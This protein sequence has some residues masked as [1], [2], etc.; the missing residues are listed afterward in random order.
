MRIFGTDRR[1]SS[2]CSEVFAVLSGDVCPGVFRCFCAAGGMSFRFSENRGLMFGY[3]LLFHDSFILF[4]VKNNV[5]QHAYYYHNT[6]A[7]H[8]FCGLAGREMV[9]AVMEVSRRFL[10][11]LS[12]LGVVVW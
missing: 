12:G 4:H 11:C 9:C 6:F 8:C 10:V 1:V 3:L 2:S 5:V 7:P